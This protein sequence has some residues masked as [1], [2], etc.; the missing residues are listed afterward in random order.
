MFRGNHP[1]K[2]DDKGRLKLPAAFN[3]QLEVSHI[4][5]FYVTS[6]DGKSAQIWPIQTWEAREKVLARNSMKKEV[7][8]YTNI[9][10]YFGQ[11]ARVDTQSRLVLPQILRSKAA[12]DSEV[13]VFGKMDYLE[14][15]NREVFERSLTE[16]VLTDE[17]RE[18]LA[19]ILDA[20]PAPQAED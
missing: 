3:A 15:V 16:N 9:T 18:A 13:V 5:D 14:V 20:Q 11:E 12:L 10:S 2:I 8:K 4:A 1:A 6:E 7:R 19:T 17:D